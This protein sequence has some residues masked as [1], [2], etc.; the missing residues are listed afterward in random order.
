MDMNNIN[1]IISSL[2]DDD[3]KRLQ[4]IAGSIMKNNTQPQAQPQNSSVSNDL[5]NIIST[6]GALNS[7]PTKAPETSNQFN[8]DPEM[9]SKISFIMQKLNAVSNDKRYIFLNSLKP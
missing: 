5:S 1:D 2:S 7:Q 3:I 8:L 9:I 6:F 4:D